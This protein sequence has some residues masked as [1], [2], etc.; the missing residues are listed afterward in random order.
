MFNSLST[1][2]NRIAIAPTYIIHSII[3]IYST[4]RLNSKTV[5]F[6]NTITRFHTEFTGFLLVI[7]RRAV[8]TAANEKT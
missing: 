7:T 1:N 6:P 3:P 4:P 2:I 8:I 5:T